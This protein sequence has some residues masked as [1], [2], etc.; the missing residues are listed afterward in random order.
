MYGVTM[1]KRNTNRVRVETLP[2]KFTLVA[3]DNINQT[4]IL[5]TKG[6]KLIEV[7]QRVCATA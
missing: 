3:T 5:K 2:G 4:L 7:P 1:F 6:G